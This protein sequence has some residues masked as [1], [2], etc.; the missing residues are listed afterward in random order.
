MTFTILVI[1]SAVFFVIALLAFVTHLGDPVDEFQA[2]G[3]FVGV[4]MLMSI[5]FELMALLF[6]FHPFW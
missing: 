2:T 3:Q 5:F 4:L 1:L 6:H